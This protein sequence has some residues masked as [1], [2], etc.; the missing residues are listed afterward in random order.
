M[1]GGTKEGF[2]GCGVG[3]GLSEERCV[4]QEGLLKLC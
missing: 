1:V 3:V 4:M 2:D